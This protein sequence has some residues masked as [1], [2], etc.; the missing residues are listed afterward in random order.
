MR[1]P[2]VAVAKLTLL[3]I[4]LRSIATGVVLHNDSQLTD[5]HQQAR[6]KLIQKA[7]PSYFSCLLTIATVAVAEVVGLV[8]VVPVHLLVDS[9]SSDA[10]WR[11]LDLFKGPTYFY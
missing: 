2:H 3:R 5:K 4:L 1:A 11:G 6:M 8:S 7:I 9:P 10:W